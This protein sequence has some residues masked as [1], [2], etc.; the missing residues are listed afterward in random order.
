MWSSGFC[1][2]VGLYVNMTLF[3]A[4][5]DFSVLVVCTTYG[6]LL[7]SLHEIWLWHSEKLAHD[8]CRRT[9]RGGGGSPLAWKLLG[10]TLFS[11]QVQV[12]QN[13]WMIKIISIQWKISG[14]T[15]FFKASRSCSKMFDDKKYIQCSEFTPQPV[16]QVKRKLH[17]I[18][19]C[20]KYIQCSEKFQGKLCFSGQVQCCSKIM[21]GE[22]IVNAVRNHLG[23]I[24]VIWASVSAG[25]MAGPNGP[26]TGPPPSSGV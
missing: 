7:K 12:A 8:H 26:D 4:W 19:E 15:L 16:I 22:K 6:K 9:R 20:W 24:R 11:G 5:F 25:Y 17:K 14:Q 18:L 13:S 1:F 2:C 3:V 10:Q 21:N 23:V